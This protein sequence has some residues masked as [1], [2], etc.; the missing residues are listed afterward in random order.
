MKTL[1]K[2]LLASIMLVA[3]S[4]TVAS[5]DAKA[6]QK[7]Y[8]K[9]LKVCQK[10]GVKNGAV[11]ATKHDRKTWESHKGANTLVGEWKKI[12]PSGTK[13]FD[14]MKEKDLTN[15]YDFVWKYASDGEVPSCG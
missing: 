9:K 1:L 15:L 2:T 8:L 3:M 5:A 6:G 10:D 11:F 12:C 14:K 4:T 7:H 13:E